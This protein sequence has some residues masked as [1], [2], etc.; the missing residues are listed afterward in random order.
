MKVM[1]LMA[2]GTHGGAETYFE[3]TVIALA[4]AGIDQQI[5]TRAYPDRMIRLRGAGLSV[6]PA[7]FGKWLDFGTGTTIRTLVRAFQPDIIHSWMGR[8][9]SALPA[10]S[11]VNIGWFGGYY[12]L[13]RFARADMF[14]GCTP[15]IARHIRE[16]GIAEDRVT[17][18]ATFAGLDEDP[19]IDR[20]ACD[21]PEEVPLILC[22]ARLHPKKGLDTLLDALVE[23]PGAWLWI[24][25]DGPLQGEL[26][27]Q[28]ERLG[29]TDRVRFL[30]W[31]T[32]RGA[33]LRTADLLA[34]PSRYEPFGTVMVEAWQT[35]TP[36]VAAAAQG[37]AATVE[38]G[39]NGLLVPIDDV[40]A[41]A[42]ALRRVIDDPALRARLVAGGRQTYEARFTRAA[43]VSAWRAA[44]ERAMALGKR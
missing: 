7:R 22:L 28:A 38:D 1:Q 40:S 8:A 31:R 4:E 39:E 14:V 44:Y 33:L 36:L 11:A 43:V 17:S 6:T 34:V 26:M 37:P 16:A 9:A 25:G 30:G 21:T 23:L 27:A 19:A 29:L 35:G 2:G 18:V 10:A 32:D 42:A 41:L 12:D 5:V 3:D 13:K 20:A 15:D 24:A